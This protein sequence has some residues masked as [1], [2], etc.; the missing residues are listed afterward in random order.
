MAAQLP[1]FTLDLR[2]DMSLNWEH[3]E[4]T[5]NSYAVLMG[6]RTVD[7]AEATKKLAALTYALTKA[8]RLALKTPYHGGELTTR[9]TQHKIKKT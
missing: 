1:T 2:G 6:Y 7:V 9:M 8:T 5:F 4:D 3:F